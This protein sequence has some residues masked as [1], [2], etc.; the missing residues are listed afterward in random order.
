MQQLWAEVLGLVQEGEGWGLSP[1]ELV[2]LNRHNEDFETIDPVSERIASGFSWSAPT[3]W[4][5]LTST[6]VLMAI[7]IHEPK[8]SD[9][10]SASTTLRKL[11]GG[12]RR[13][14]NG[15]TLF[16]VPRANSDF[17]RVAG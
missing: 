16:A 3:G 12:Q 11:N 8:K 15:L 7:G 2:A 5:W 13:K 9:T 4:D 6:Q 1:T 14:S 10:I 17:M